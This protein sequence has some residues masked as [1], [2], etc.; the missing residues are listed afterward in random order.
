M[1]RTCR[2]F[3]VVL[4]ILVLPGLVVAAEESKAKKK[5]GKGRKAGIALFDGKSLEGWEVN[6]VDPDVKMEDVWS[7]Q[8]GIMICKGEPLGYLATKQEFTN[9]K[10]LLQWRWAPGGKPGNSGVLL[11]AVGE[12]IGFMP[13]CVE[14]QL[15]NG[16]AGDIWAFRGANAT[17]AEDRLRKIED[18]QALG[19]FVGVGKIKAAEKEPGKWNT[20]EIVFQ[21][22]KLTLT[23]NGELVNEATG[24]DVVARFGEVRRPAPSATQKCARPFA[25]RSPTLG[26]GQ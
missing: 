6:L 23:I 11:R 5:K 8:D 24:C 21:G 22:D 9:Y 20:Y 10:L 1:Y 2:L 12:P 3:T 18:H 25:L 17:G 13:K 14:A 4:L 7:V 26:T 19:D 16:S 15:M